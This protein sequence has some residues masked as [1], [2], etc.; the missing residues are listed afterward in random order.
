MT[1]VADVERL[2]VDP[3]DILL[4]H[5][6]PGRWDIGERRDGR[7]VDE[8]SARN[9]ERVDASVRATRPRLVIHGHWH[10]RY[11]HTIDWPDGTHSTVIGLG[12]NVDADG[13]DT[14][15]ITDAAVVVDLDTLTWRRPQ[16]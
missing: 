11:D 16:G 6:A 13:N 8:R 1:R 9:R 14:D 4:T 3:V 15:D 5:D 12:A 7:D 2:G 10:H